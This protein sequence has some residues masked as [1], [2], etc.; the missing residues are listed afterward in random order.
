MKTGLFVRGASSLP[1]GKQNRSVREPI[2]FML[3][4]VRSALAAS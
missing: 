4:G 1:F 3:T 2:E